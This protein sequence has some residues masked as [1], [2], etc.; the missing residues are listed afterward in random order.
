LLAAARAAGVAGRLWVPADGASVS[1]T[2]VVAQ[3]L[4]A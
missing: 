3:A 2:H 1:F 4:P